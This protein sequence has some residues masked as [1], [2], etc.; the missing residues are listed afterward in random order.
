MKMKKLIVA[1]KPSV[2]RDIA[3][4]LGVKGRAEGYIDGDGYAVTWALGHLVALCEPDELDEK[5]KKWRWDDLPIAPDNIPLKVLPKTRTQ[6]N[7][8]KKLMNSKEISSII[9][10]TDSAREGELIFRYIYEKAGCKKSVERLWIS[11]MTDQ[12][13]RQGF[14]RL[15]PASD[16]DALYVSAK[17][18]SEAD[19]IVGMNASRAFS[20]KYN[21]N[22]P[23]GRVQT[24]T[25]S[26]LVER[27][28][29]IA[30]FVPRDYWEVRADFGDYEGLYYDGES[31][32]SKLFD[33]EK[34]R[35]IRAEVAGKTGVVKESSREMKSMPP[36]QLFDLTTLQREANRKY[37]YPADKTLKLAQSLYETHKI[38][39]YPRTDSRYLSSDMPPKIAETIRRLPEPYAALARSGDFDP[40]VKSKR[41][42]DDSR[43]S[44]HH[45]IVPTDKRA[46]L[47]R[48]TQDERN[49]YD[50]VARRIIA[51]HYPDYKY[52]AAKISTMVG[53]HEFRSTGSVPVREGWRALY[54]DEKKAKAGEELP[55]VAVGDERRVR[56]ASV[57]QQKTKPPQPHNDASI[58]GL[59]E[60]AGTKLE[61]PELRE[62]MKSAGLGTPATRAA[63][64]ERL[65]SAGYAA[66]RGKTIVS[67][68]K[69]RR[70]IAVTPAQ[71]TS[72]VTTGK[73]EKALYDLANNP[74][75][76]S[77]G[78]KADRFMS[79]IGRF[80]VFLVD[81]ARQADPR[82]EFERTPPKKR[83]ARR[84]AP[85]KK[86]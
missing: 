22:L 17:C 25:L 85:K 72:P 46:D 58:L 29:E 34:A 70:L 68:E 59:M 2:A 18:R 78:A 41:Y 67:T 86:G 82:V 69:G 11:S 13:I 24:P 32:D 77:R 73:W 14:A 27:D 84:A 49:I 9:C 75:N 57:K 60:N 21:A 15:R 3:R 47:E 5:Y 19:W 38:L 30:N 65:I 6:F 80:A 83:T 71:I 55:N 12:A 33:E 79:G 48:L 63:I 43:I 56:R 45:A 40:D 31:K 37:G 7:V 23:V 1:E 20:L 44:D 8:V 26:M 54:R 16:Y 50:M 51:M 61:D 81:A 53:P 28:N 42:Y 64:I 10:A 62:R 76:A 4:V 66:R 35:A 39:T 36:P 52:E 74:D